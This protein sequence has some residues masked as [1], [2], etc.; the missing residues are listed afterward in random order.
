[1]VVRLDFMNICAMNF[2]WEVRRML[3]SSR[4]RVRGCPYRNSPFGLAAKSDR[5]Q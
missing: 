4:L 5:S 3:G 1:M 2:W